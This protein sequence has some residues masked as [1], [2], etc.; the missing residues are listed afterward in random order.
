MIV[1]IHMEEEVVPQ[2]SLQEALK[3]N[4]DALLLPVGAEASQDAMNL[5]TVILVMIHF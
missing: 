3:R 2:G 4:W 1:R 5:M